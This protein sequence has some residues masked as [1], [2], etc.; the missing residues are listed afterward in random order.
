M[1][2][3][4]GGHQSSLFL[5]DIFWQELRRIADEQ[6]IPVDR[7]I[8]QISEEDVGGNLARAVRLYVVRDLQQWRMLA[9]R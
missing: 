2:K 5:E 7:L 9:I 1:I 6:G 4:E 3:L 8:R